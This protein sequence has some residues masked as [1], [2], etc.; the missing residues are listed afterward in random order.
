ML[1]TSY[2]SK[3]LTVLS[4]KMPAELR[5]LCVSTLEANGED[6]RD[7]IEAIVSHLGEHSTA[8]L[9]KTIDELSRQREEI[10]VELAEARR[11]AFKEREVESRK[12]EVEDELL[13]PYEAAQYVAQN[14]DELEGIIPGDVKLSAH[15]DMP[16]IAELYG[17][18]N[19][20]TAE[21]EDEASRLDDVDWIGFG[22]KAGIC[23]QG[24]LKS[25]AVRVL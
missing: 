13:T 23:M 16:M 15:L 21:D 10:L 6:A 18:N 22:A 5:G 25:S 17:S 8:E 7:S 3:A 14:K 12:F 4:D 1:V 24:A 9:K 11:G 19:V 2:T 20:V